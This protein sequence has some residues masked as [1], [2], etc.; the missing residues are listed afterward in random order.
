RFQ[1]DLAV[2]ESLIPQIPNG[3]VRISESGIFD[4]EDAERARACGADAILV[5]EALM[6][7]E[8]PEALVKA[9]H[10]A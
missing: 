10:N 4:P 3:V 5:G 8:N 1:T 6:R 9:F 7:A 2:S